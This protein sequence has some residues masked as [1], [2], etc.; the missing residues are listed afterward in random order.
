[1]HMV[2]EQEAH[3]GA[4]LRAEEVATML[5]LLRQGLLPL[6][7]KRVAR[8][9]EV[10]LEMRPQG[11][12]ELR[13]NATGPVRDLASLE[14]ELAKR[15]ATVP[16]VEADV[17]ELCLK[18]VQLRAQL[19]HAVPRA[20]RAPALAPANMPRVHGQPRDCS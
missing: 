16:L 2:K 10:V 13:E 15:R 4:G 19:R 9:E 5:D 11:M 20:P 7:Q 1:M 12:M 14:S 8:L 17:R 18:H 6:L 3:G